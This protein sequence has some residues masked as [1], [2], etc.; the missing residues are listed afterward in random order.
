MRGPV[1]TWKNPRLSSAIANGT[2]RSATD[3]VIAVDPGGKG[4]AAVCVR[5]KGRDGRLGDLTWHGP[6][7]WER[8]AAYPPTEPRTH[9]E[10]RVRIHTFVVAN[11][12]D[13][14]GIRGISDKLGYPEAI[15]RLWRKRGVLP[16]PAAILAGSPVW[17]WAEVLRWAHATG[18]DDRLKWLP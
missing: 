4:W 10:A 13:A 15:V 12:G 3:A 16:Y 1:R 7:P 2:A 8:S 6:E 17:E 11:V 5:P 14:V 9:V 18:R